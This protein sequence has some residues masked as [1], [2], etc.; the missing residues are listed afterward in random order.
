IGYDVHAEVGYRALADGAVTALAD[1]SLKAFG[2]AELVVIATP[3]DAAF[4]ILQRLS[5]LS[6]STALLTDVGSTK[7]SIVAGAAALGLAERF[8]GSHPLV[9]DHRSGWDAARTGL[10]GGGRVFLC[11]SDQVGDEAI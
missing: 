3:V 7:T 9:G 1:D 2:D 10:Y 4:S 5:V 6:D 11:P 8:V